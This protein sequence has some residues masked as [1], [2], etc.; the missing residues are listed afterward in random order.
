M[1]ASSIF[2]LSLSILICKLAEWI[3]F[4]VT[5]LLIPS[6]YTPDGRPRARAGSDSSHTQP[7]QRR[8]GQETRGSDH[9]L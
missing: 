7:K 9:I 5:R 4:E 2:P 8:E 3:H 6:P 1:V